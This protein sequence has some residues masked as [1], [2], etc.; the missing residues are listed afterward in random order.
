MAASVGFIVGKFYPPHK[1]HKYLI[2]TARRQV[3]RLIVMIPHHPSQTIPGEV[4][5]DWLRE[6]HPDCD[7]RLVPDD[8]ENNSQSWADFIVRYLG[9]APDVVFSS[10]DYGPEFAA[11]MGSR[12]V[13]I[14]RQRTTVPISA[15]AIRQAPLDYLNFLEPCVRAYFIK[16]VVLIGAESTGKTTL[17]ATLAKLFQTTWVPEYGREHWE[18][19]IAGRTMSEPL[20]S[21]SPEEFVQI[22]AEQQAR[23]NM[24]ARS[25]NR[26]LFCDTNAFA[27]GT[28]FERY[29]KSRNPVVDAIGAR[30][31][32]NLYLLCGADAP[33]VQDGVRDGEA[34]RD[35]M[36]GRFTAQLEAMKVPY[37]VLSGAFAERDAKAI[38]AVRRLLS[39]S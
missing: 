33:F 1:G 18:R 14:D 32:V 39:S 15:T 12:H 34:I 36:Q 9:K 13:M 26:V 35:W 27:T 21:W 4:R 23:E 30:D 6:I 38:A 24:A 17:A 22:A 25:A 11:M 28:W 3:D 7:V 5:R 37:M 20:P 2:D 16:R 10:E 8:L 29:Q 31:K 19:K